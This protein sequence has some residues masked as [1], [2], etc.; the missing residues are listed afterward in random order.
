MSNSPLRKLRI[1]RITA[2]IWDNE[3]EE[4]KKRRSINIVRNYKKGDDW[5]ETSSFSEE[6]L[7]VVRRLS[8]MALNISMIIDEAPAEN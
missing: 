5:F 1:G 2:T 6:D 7:P 3:T 4:G 8:E